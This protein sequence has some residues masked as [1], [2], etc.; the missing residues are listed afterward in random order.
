MGSTGSGR[1]TDYSGANTGE[2][3]GSG[4]G[5][6]SS[7][8]DRCQQSFSCTLEEVAQCEY[9]VQTSSTPTTGTPLTLILEGRLFATT[10]D[11]KKVGALPT[12]FNYLAACLASGFSYAGI[13]QTSTNS[14]VPSVRVD[15]TPI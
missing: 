4:G 1:F 2:T 3:T 15:F 12:S 13:I 8:N 7:G 5:G 10:A 9:F 11:N 6:G 14:P